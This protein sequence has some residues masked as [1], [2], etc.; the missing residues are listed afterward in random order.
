MSNRTKRALAAGLLACLAAAA[1]AETRPAISVVAVASE[2]APY[3]EALILRGRTEAVRRVEVK[4]EISGLVAS[5][6]LRKGAGV[7]AG[8]PLCRLDEGDRPAELAEAEA[9]MVEA[10][11]NFDAASELSKK[12]FTSETKANA[13]VAEL[14]QARARVLRARLDLDRMT[15]AA[16]FDGI[17]E[18]DTAELG[19]LLTNGATCAT[20][21]ALDP[22]KLIAYAPERT[23]DSLVAG[24]LVK[25]RLVTGREVEARLVFVARSADRDTRTYLVEAEAANADLSIR[26]GM[27]AELDIG[28]SPQMAHLLPQT[29]LTLDD[30]GALGVRIAEAGVARFVPVEILRDEPRGVWVDG[31]PERAEVIVVGQE[32]V[33]DGQPVDVRR[34]GAEA[35]Q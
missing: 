15:I 13:M 34:L 31:L 18:T 30:E 7:S 21:I 35:T 6:P 10:Q 24:A 26:D 16:P 27:T 32:F 5:P 12:G 3:A 9:R 22:I 1:G 25:A 20:V 29:A 19:A 33:I 2:A 14:E 17:L 4:A 8:E 23:V 28:L 11:L